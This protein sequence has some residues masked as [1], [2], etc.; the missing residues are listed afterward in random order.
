M[1]VSIDAT[2][3]A[4]GFYPA[5]GG[6]YRVSIAPCRS[7]EPIALLDRGDV[8]LRARALVA[9]LPHTIARREVSIV[10]ERLGLDRE[11]CHAETVES[12]IGPGN[13]LMIAVEGDVVTETVTGFGVKG[14]S[15]EQ[16][17]SRACSEVRALLDAGVPVGPHLADQLLIPMALAGGGSFRTVEPSSHAVTNAAVIRQFIDVPIAFDREE[18]NVYRVL[19]GTHPRGKAS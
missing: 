12:S 18:G 1:G 2:L 13:V 5:G 10:R 4:Y 15:A 7:L 17:A 14:I 3:D 9:A 16:V 8:R 11:S 6:R 19:V